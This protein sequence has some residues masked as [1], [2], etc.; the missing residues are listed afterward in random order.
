MQCAKSH[1]PS[2]QIEDTPG[3]A[4]YALAHDFRAKGND[5]AY[6]DTLRYIVARYPSSRRSAAAKIE[7]ASDS[8]ADSAP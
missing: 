4:L 1:D 2:L 6:R 7:L 5:L 8:G 3:D